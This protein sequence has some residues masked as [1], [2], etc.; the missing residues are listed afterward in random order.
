MAAST[1][2]QVKGTRA[3]SIL[4]S[5]P[6]D[7]KDGGGHGGCRP[8]IWLGPLSGVASSACSWRSPGAFRTCGSQ[9]WYAGAAAP[10]WWAAPSCGGWRPLVLI[11]LPGAARAARKRQEVAVACGAY[12]C[13]RWMKF[14]P[15]SDGSRSL[16]DIGWQCWFGGNP[17]SLTT[18]AAAFS[19][20]PFGG[21]IEAC[22][23]PLHRPLLFPG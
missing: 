20:I 13:R 8:S 9:A 11:P 1:S 6:P 4:V 3:P 10:G 23:S 22:T 19:S 16:R 15:P 14:T 7:P 21:V 17:W 12:G 2:G 18:M 5:P